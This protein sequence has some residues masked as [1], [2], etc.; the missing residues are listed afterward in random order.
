MTFL[1]RAREIQRLCQREEISY[2]MQF[3]R[4]LPFPA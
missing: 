3:H 2:L 4:N 1:R